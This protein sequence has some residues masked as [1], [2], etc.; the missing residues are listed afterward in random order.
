MKRAWRSTGVSK[1]AETAPSDHIEGK[2]T[3]VIRARPHFYPDRPAWQ[4]GGKV[5]TL[6]HQDFGGQINGRMYRLRK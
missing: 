2:G 3:H 6:I 4:N 1:I 5:V